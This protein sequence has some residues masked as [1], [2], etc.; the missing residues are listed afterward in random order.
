MIMASRVV[1][2]SDTAI[3]AVIVV[4]T[5]APIINGPAFLSETIFFATTGTMSDVVIVLERIAA[6]VVSPQKNDFQYPNKWRPSFLGSFTS[7]RSETSLRK[8]SIDPNNNVN[9]IK[10]SV[11]P[12]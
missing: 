4:P 9:E 10:L 11:S 3:I 6:V 8:A 1:A 5:F 7:R 2:L 12:D